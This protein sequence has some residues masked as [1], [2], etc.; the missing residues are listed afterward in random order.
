MVKNEPIPSIKPLKSY[1]HRIVCR[2]PQGLEVSTSVNSKLNKIMILFPN[3]F[4]DVKEE[5]S[6]QW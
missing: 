6:K 5:L 4:W 3:T 2:W 1:L